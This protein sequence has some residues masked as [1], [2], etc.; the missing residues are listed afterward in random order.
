[1]Y[2]VL[3]RK[4]VSTSTDI[5]EEVIETVLAYLQ[6]LV[7]RRCCSASTAGNQYKYASRGLVPSPNLSEWLAVV[8]YIE[9]RYRGDQGGAP[10]S[11]P[12]LCSFTLLED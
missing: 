1:M 12:S 9:S 11:A 7:A 5:K 2:G 3:Q 6:V 8:W 10:N 4:P